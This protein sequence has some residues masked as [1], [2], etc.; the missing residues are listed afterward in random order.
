[1]VWWT[2]DR[3]DNGFFR[4]HGE[5]LSR[6]HLSPAHLTFCLIKVFSSVVAAW[7]DINSA[8]EVAAASIHPTSAG[9]G[10]GLVG[11]VVQKLNIGYI[12][13]L[14]NCM[15]SAA[16]V[17][18]ISFWW[19]RVYSVII[20][21]QVLAMR[22]RIKVTGFSDWETMFYNNL[23]SIPVLAVFSIL[24]ENWSADNLARNL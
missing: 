11:G 17:R 16:Y 5:R 19:L 2:S 8:S 24:V 20:Y 9:M 1:M 15:A 12:W 21:S 10:L 13:M 23:L 18:R 22:K 7:A 6:V 4:I 3:A 14:V